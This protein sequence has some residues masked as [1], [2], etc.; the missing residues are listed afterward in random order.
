MNVARQ[1]FSENQNFDFITEDYSR[2]LP[3]GNFD[4]IC[5]ALSIH[6]MEDSD[7]QLLYNLVFE[8]LTDKGCF[9]N[10]ESSSGLKGV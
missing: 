1:R 6:H 3:D 8:K 9:I 5:S 7:K 4:L 2:K 10:L